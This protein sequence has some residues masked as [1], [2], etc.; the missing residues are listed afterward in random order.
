[1][2]Q[3]TASP[4]ARLA[5]PE[6]L[7]AGLLLADELAEEE[8]EE[9]DAEADE[10][11]RRL[12]GRDLDHV[13]RVVLGPELA[14]AQRQL[15]APEAVPERLLEEARERFPGAVVDDGA[16]PVHQL[17]P[18]VDGAEVQV[19]LLRLLEPGV[20]AAD[21]LEDRF[22]VG[23]V[24]A[25]VGD[26]DALVEHPHALQRGETGVA[27]PHLFPR[28]DISARCGKRLL[29]LLHPEGVADGV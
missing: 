1:M 16:L 12:V 15:L 29:H 13:D 18:R 23:E 10:L 14:V 25:R 6:K 8:A 4:L 19:D 7:L 21:G 17:V 11:P 9:R 3:P 27:Q 5:L 28:N 20:E 26:V 22:P 2:A 24:D